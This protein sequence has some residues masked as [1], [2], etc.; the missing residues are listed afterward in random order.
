[1]FLL[2]L[3]L[4]VVSLVFCCYWFVYL[5]CLNG[6]SVRGVWRVVGC[7]FCYGFGCCVVFYCW[8]TVVFVYLM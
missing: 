2:H 1:M 3:L 7:C 5:A 6:S 8:F 4:L